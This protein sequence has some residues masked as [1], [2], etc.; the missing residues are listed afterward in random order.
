MTIPAGQD[1]E[2]REH[3]A[4]HGRP[5]LHGGSVAAYSDGPG[6]G[7]ELVVRLPA[8]RIEVVKDTPLTMAPQPAG[9]TARATRQR[10]L[11]AYPIA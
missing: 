7:S 6:E 10:A 4:R 1:S 3:G 2:T 5:R 8:A 11:S 9:V